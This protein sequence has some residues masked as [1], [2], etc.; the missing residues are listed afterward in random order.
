[1]PGVYLNLFEGQRYKKEVGA[2]SPQDE[3]KRS[4]PDTGRSKSQSALFIVSPPP[5]RR[6]RSLSPPKTSE[7]PPIEFG[8]KLLPGSIQQ[9]DASEARTGKFL[10]H[11]LFRFA[12]LSDPHFYIFHLEKCSLF[13]CSLF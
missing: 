10:R 12:A 4:R 13:S 5:K 1:M 11:F 6:K 8:Q 2:K 3:R 9:K 7:P